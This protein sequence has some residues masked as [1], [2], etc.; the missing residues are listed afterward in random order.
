MP[1][2]VL[3]PM[4][5][6]PSE[7]RLGAAL[8]AQE[9]SYLAASARM[10]RL[11]ISC[12]GFLDTVFIYSI[13]MSRALQAPNEW[14]EPATHRV[15]RQKDGSSVIDA[16]PGRRRAALQQAP[17]LRLT[18]ALHQFFQ[19][20][21]ILHAMEIGVVEKLGKIGVVAV[22]RHLRA[23]TQAGLYARH[24]VF[25]QQAFVRAQPQQVGGVFDE[26]R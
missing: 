6:L 7:L 25:D 9:A 11:S 2:P 18:D 4:P 5:D 14:M 20:T 24:T 21:K 10:L 26:D 23:S 16:T 22:T 1:M 3:E 19:F 17:P 8:L 13:E 15:C 12:M